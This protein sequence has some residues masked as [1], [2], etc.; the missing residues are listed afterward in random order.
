M[1]QLF[2]YEWQAQVNETHLTDDDS[3]ALTRVTAAMAALKRLAS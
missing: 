1:C 2:Y 3:A